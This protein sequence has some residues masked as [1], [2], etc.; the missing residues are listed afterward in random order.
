MF[1]SQPL[2]LEVGRWGV[3]FEGG[4]VKAWALW[5]GQNNYWQ[6]NA[7]RAQQAAILAHGRFP[8]LPLTNFDLAF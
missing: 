8:E 4:S 3:V 7:A 2:A 1:F 5:F 6:N